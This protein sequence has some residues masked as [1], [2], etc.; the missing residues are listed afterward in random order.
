[1]PPRTPTESNRRKESRS[2][3]P[4]V[5]GPGYFRQT[6]EAQGFHGFP[7]VEATAPAPGQGQREP[8]VRGAIRKQNWLARPP[9][10]AKIGAFKKGPVR[11]GVPRVGEAGEYGWQGQRRRARFPQVNGGGFFDAAPPWRVGSPP[12]ALTTARRFPVKV[13]SMVGSGPFEQI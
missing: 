12:V 2:R 5:V 7:P 9:V 3:T 6:I 1:V 4:S 11:V 13:Q 8:E 10:R